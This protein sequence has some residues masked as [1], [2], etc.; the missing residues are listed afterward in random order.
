MRIGKQ[1]GLEEK[2]KNNEEKQ[3]DTLTKKHYA[4]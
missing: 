1:L 2:R 4:V 3:K